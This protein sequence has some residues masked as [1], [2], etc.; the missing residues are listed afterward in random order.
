MNAAQMLP[1]DVT[2]QLVRI[3]LDG[4]RRTERE[5]P[6]TWARVKRRAAE[7]RKRGEYDCGGKENARPVAAEP[8]T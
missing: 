1:E 4:M 7:I 5:D 2:K 6:E 3:I 8:S